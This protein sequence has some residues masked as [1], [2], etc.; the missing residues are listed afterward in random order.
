MSETPPIALEHVACALCGADDTHVRHHKFNLIVVQCN[1]CRL[2][3]TNPRLPKDHLWTRYSEDY[4]WDEYLRSLEIGRDGRVD[5][6]RFAAHHAPLLDLFQAYHPPPGRLLEVGAAAGLFMK[7]AERAGWTVQGLEPLPAPARF[8]RERFGLDVLQETVESAP[9]GEATFDAVAM[10]ETI[11]HVLDPLGVLS[12]VRRLLRQR[13]LLVLTTPNWEALTRHALGQ[14]WAVISPAEH[15]YYFSEA[16]LTAMLTR[17]GFSWVHYHRDFAPG[18][19]ETMMPAYTHAPGSARRRL[20]A[21][22]VR[23]LGPWL[24]REVQRRGLADQLVCIARA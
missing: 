6:D 4:F 13:G 16:T 20:Y 14:Q 2:V 12:A 17:A 5:L 15:L 22:F 7:S 23:T 11:E 1:R 18:A 19:A 10:F 3:Y 21:G 24:F 8:A 9:F